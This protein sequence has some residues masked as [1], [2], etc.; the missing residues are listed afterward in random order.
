L[1]K[2][3]IAFDTNGGPSLQIIVSPA[4]AARVRP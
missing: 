4:D 2:M 3:D 1:E